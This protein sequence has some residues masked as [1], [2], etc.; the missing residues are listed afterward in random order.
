[1]SDADDVKACEAVCPATEIQVYSGSDIDSATTARGFS[2]A[3]LPN[4]F[5]FRREMVASCTCNA[6]TFVG[7]TTVSIE[8]DPTIRSG[9]IVAEANGFA[10]A[11]N[12][13]SA[14]RPIMF[15]PLS[16]AKARALGLV[17]LSVR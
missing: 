7:L 16:Q 17:R 2:Y 8:N 3:K 15:R 14:H 1:V 9:D 4:A 5:R 10:I 12:G 11:S 6:R 13:G